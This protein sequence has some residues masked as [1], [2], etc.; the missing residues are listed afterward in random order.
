[1]KSLIAILG[2]TLSAGFFTIAASSLA[3]AQQARNVAEFCGVWQGICNRTGSRSECASR[4]TEC[5]SSGCFHFNR[6]GPRCFSN[7]A[8]RALTDVRLA[9]N[10][11][12]ERARRAK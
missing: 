9:P 8:D 10:P 6:P 5:R 12:R 2:F 4:A 7:A 1:M 3:D 11:E